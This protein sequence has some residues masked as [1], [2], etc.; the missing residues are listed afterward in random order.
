MLGVTPSMRIPTPRQIES[1]FKHYILQ[2]L[3][4]ILAS[5]GILFQNWLVG[6]VVQAP[7]QTLATTVVWLAIA[8]LVVT[9]VG[10]F[11]FF[12]SRTLEKAVLEFDPNY[13]NH[14]EYK[15]AFVEFTKDS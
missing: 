11:Y 15:E 8:V 13:Y 10:A 14:R 9:L 4:G 12:K 5:L 6:L 3:A 7:S 2:I 1:T